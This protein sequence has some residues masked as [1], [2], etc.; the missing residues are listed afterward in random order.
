MKIN[1]KLF[2]II[3]QWV[4]SANQLQLFLF[5]VFLFSS[6]LKV[7]IVVRSVYISQDYGVYGRVLFLH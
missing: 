4:E 6:F 3:S 1:L 2:F 5:V 7:S